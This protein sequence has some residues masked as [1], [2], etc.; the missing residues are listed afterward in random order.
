MPIS[1]VEDIAAG[2]RV[3]NEVS[4]NVTAVEETFGELLRRLRDRAR[5]NQAEF[6]ARIG[7]SE[8]GYA[9]IENNPGRP[10][11]DNEVETVKKMAEVLSVPTRLLSEKLGWVSLE[12]ARSDD[13]EMAIWNDQRFSEEDRQ[14]LIQAGRN[15]LAAKRTRE[16]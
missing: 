16:P 15:A 5:I 2:S 10:S 12:E 7:R 9:L 13:W 3:R 6:A 8:K 1:S 4:A 14:M 11:I